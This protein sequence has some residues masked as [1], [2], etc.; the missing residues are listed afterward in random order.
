LGV[1]VLLIS[2]VQ[3][4]AQVA[5]RDAVIGTGTAGPLVSGVG[6]YGFLFDAS[7]GPSGE[8]PA[9]TATAVL[10]PFPDIN[11]GGRV[12]CLAVEG[13]RAVIGTE[14]G[15]D[16]VAPNQGT[17]FE[18][19]DDSPDSVAFGTV[20]EPPTVCPAETGFEQFELVTGDIAVTDAPAL[21]TSKDQCKHGGWRSFPGFKNQG[22]CVSFVVT[23]G[24]NP[25]A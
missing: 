13:N 2:P 19:V 12:T 25:P 16:T 15:P 7:S 5:A 4:Q 18:V 9:G 8:S 3:V 10:V 1:L 11:T 17:L 6:I 23:R 20:P 24:K 21:P 14:N 22:D